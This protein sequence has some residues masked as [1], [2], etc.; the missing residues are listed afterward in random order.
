MRKLFLLPL[1][2]QLALDYNRIDASSLLESQNFAS[3]KN[4]SKKQ[5]NTGG[6]KLHLTAS[7]KE[8]IANEFKKSVSEFLDKN[9]IENFGVAKVVVNKNSISVKIDFE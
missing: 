6:K 5:N 4:N 7:D 9:Y 3:L 2:F 1:F 8:K